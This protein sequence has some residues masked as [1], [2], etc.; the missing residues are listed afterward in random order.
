MSLPA[1]LA[2]ADLTL[3]APPRISQAY[4]V[5]L[6]LDTINSDTRPIKPTH[7]IL[8]AAIG[9]CWARVRARVPFNGDVLDYGSR[10]IDLL[11]DPTIK[12]APGDRP[13]TM[14]DLVQVGRSAVELIVASVPSA[15]AV[16]KA[17]NFS[18]SRSGESSASGSQSSDGGPASQDGSPH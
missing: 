7:V 4:A 13:A 10:V 15:A 9:L 17:E 6:A 18:D 8:A 1:R 12:L 16:E 11:L 3:T 14:L 5:I 2:G